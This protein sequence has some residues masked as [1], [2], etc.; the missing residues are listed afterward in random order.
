LLLAVALAALSGCLLISGEQTT[1]DLGDGGGNLLT[2]FVSAEGS[3]ERTL[4]VGSP[5]AELQLIAVVEVDSGDLEL[6]VLQPDGAVAF[7]VRARPAT[8]V[9]R[10]GPVLADDAGR[11]RYRVRA[12][13]ASD[14]SYQIFVQ[15]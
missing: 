5:D 6:T 15:P 8:Q 7:T 4:E 12:Q 2:T 1:L 3:E 13:G 9:T 14:G 10:S 11:V